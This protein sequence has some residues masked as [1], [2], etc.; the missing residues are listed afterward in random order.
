[1]KM[2]TPWPARPAQQIDDFAPGFEVVEQE[3]HALEVGERLEVFEQMRLA[4]HDQLAF[5]A[6]AAGPAG[7]TGGNDLLRQ[8]VELGLTLLQPL[9][10]F[11]P[12]L[13]KR[14][15]RDSAN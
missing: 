10:D 13:G 9:L 6:F 12:D 2:R 3:A 1:M 14:C 11:G 5:V 7:E 8:L 4:A 15:G